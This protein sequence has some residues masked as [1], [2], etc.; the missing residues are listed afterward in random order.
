MANV[1][2]YP[3]NA[4]EKFTGL[5]PSEDAQDFISLLVRKIQFAL[6]TRPDDAGQAAV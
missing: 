2:A 3:D 6:G 5:D 1:I 4:L